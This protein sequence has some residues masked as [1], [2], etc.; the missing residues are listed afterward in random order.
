MLVN[1]GE[2]AGFA[3]ILIPSV[4]GFSKQL[5]PDETVFVTGAEA[6]WLCM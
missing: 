1:F 3:A 4:S 6:S 5:N 2:F